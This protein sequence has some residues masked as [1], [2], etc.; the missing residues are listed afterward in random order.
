[1]RYGGGATFKVTTQP[2]TSHPFTPQPISLRLPVDQTY[3]STCHQPNKTTSIETK[4][5]SLTRATERT[6]PI[7]MWERK[8]MGFNFNKQALLKINRKEKNF[9]SSKGGWIHRSA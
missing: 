3:K 5:G 1:L 4:T 2:V 9:S 7:L 8:K 6:Q